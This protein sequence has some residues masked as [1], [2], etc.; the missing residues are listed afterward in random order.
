[1]ASK[2]RIKKLSGQQARIALLKLLED[3]YS[4]T[5]GAIWN[6]KLD[7]ALDVAESY[8]DKENLDRRTTE[9]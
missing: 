4:T 7:E 6:K 8:H 2:K 9:V 3:S 5:A 1:M